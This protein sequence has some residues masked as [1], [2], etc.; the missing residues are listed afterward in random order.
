M[1]ERSDVH[2][3]IGKRPAI[4]EIV[5]VKTGRAIRFDDDDVGR[6][7]VEHDAAAAT[8]A[9]AMTAAVMAAAVM[10]AAF[11]GILGR[12]MVPKRRHQRNPEASHIPRASKPSDI[13]FRL[14]HHRPTIATPPTR[15]GC[16]YTNFI[17]PHFA[18]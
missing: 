5:V 1:R 3:V 4:S 7:I 15:Y 8:V 6:A 17:T 11:A 9:A 2:R 12:K 10:P 18:A 16:L 13:T 14:T